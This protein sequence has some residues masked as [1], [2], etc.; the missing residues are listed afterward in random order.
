M[1]KTQLKISGKSGVFD[2]PE[3]NPDL[4]QGDIL[5]IDLSTFKQGDE[6]IG[7]LIYLN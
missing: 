2:D 6:V 3:L 4:F 1:L 7:L 5:G